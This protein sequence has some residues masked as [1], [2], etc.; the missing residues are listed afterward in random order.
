M[1][2]V[3]PFGKKRWV[4]QRTAPCHETLTNT[5]F[6]TFLKPFKAIVAALALATIST[7]CIREEALNTEA[8]ITAFQ[9]DGNLLIREPVITNDEVRLYVNG[10]EDRSKLSPRF[11]LTPGA[12]ISPASGTE[13]DFTT[14][15][16][17]TV[18][19]QDGQWKK[20]YTVTFI[21]NDVQIGRAHV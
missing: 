14:P 1:Q 3:L 6:M 5:A 7:A 9:L 2:C 8:D 18:T 12:T 21:S 10:W 13:R 17:Y 19:S 16:K 15:Q 11:E 4:G 20:T